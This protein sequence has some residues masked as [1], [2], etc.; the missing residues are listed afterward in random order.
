MLV[1]D[2]SPFFYAG[3]FAQAATLAGVA[4][5]AI[6]DNANHNASV[7]AYGMAATQPTLTLP[8]AS[9]PTNPIGASVVIDS[10]NYVVA[11]HEPDGTGISRL[12]LEAA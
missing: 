12:L 2:L 10:V 8:T 6:F 5:Q 4:V 7:G 11:T 3:E 1:D 9:V